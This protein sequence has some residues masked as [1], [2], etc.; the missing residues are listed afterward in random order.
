[1]AGQVFKPDYN[2][3]DE[4]LAK[5]DDG[6]TEYKFYRDYSI[7]YLTRGCF[8]HCKFCVN[9]RQK[10]VVRHSPLAEFFEPSRKKICLLDDN[11]FGSAEWSEIFSELEESGRKFTFRQGLDARLLDEEKAQR[12]FRAKYDGDIIFAFDD[13]QDRKII[14]EKLKLIRRYKGGKTVKFYV[15]SG[16]DRRGKFDAEFFQRDLQETALRLRLLKEYDC[17]GYVMRHAAIKNS[18]YEKVYSCL[19][20]FINMNRFYGWKDFSEFAHERNK[21]VDEEQIEVLEKI[22]EGRR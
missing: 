8:R 17:K 10:K 4:W 20:A 9:R 14:E 6:S 1:M 5:N 22:L 13:W 18:G 19:S 3:Y 16:Y 2:L 11:F 15:L 7:G 12:L 21:E